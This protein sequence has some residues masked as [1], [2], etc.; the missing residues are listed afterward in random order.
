M[1]YKIICFTKNISTIVIHILVSDLS[2]ANLCGYRYIKVTSPIFKG[3][4]R[5][6]ILFG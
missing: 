3:D 1:K 4:Y 5:T 2:R 6:I